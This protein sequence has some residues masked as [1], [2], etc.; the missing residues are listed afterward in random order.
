MAEPQFTTT[1]LEAYLDED[2]PPAEMARIEQAARSNPKLTEQLADINTRRNAGVHTL[3]EIWRRNRL[4]CAKREQ[5]GGYLLGT[6]DKE[7]A[8]YLKFHLEVIECRVC[9]ANLEDLKARRKQTDE[10]VHRQKRYFESSVG[11]LQSDRK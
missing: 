8:A 6:L 5:L 2:L 3:G 9:Q 7:M 4:T 10:T 11:Y 1:A